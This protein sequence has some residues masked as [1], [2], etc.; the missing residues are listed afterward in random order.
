MGNNHIRMR[1]AMMA[2]THK[3]CQT[4][5]R[6]CKDAISLRFF[7]DSTYPSTYL[8]AL[9]SRTNSGAYFI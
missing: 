1:L 7:V 9:Q 5:T 8:I 2:H 4:P 3:Q 6:N